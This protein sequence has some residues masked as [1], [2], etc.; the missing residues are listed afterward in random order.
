M[1]RGG[2][3]GHQTPSRAVSQGQDSCPDT[4]TQLQKLE[5]EA[6]LHGGRS[7]GSQGRIDP[8]TYSNPSLGAVEGTSEV[9]LQGS[10][11]VHAVRVQGQQLQVVAPELIS[12]ADYLAHSAATRSV[13]A[14]QRQLLSPA[15]SSLDER[16]DP[17]QLNERPA[18]NAYSLAFPGAAGFYSPSGS[19]VIESI[20]SQPLSS[21]SQQPVRA[22]HH[23]AQG[24][25]S[26]IFP[27]G[28][29]PKAHP[30]KQ[31]QRSPHNP[32]GGLSSGGP[33]SVQGTS[34][35]TPSLPFSPSRTNPLQSSPVKPI[36]S[37]MSVATNQPPTEVVELRRKTLE[38]KRKTLKDV[39]NSYVDK[40]TELF[41]LQQS[42]NMMDYVIW[43]KKQPD[44][45]LAS[46]LKSRQLE[47]RI[48]DQIS[49]VKVSTSSSSNA[50]LSSPAT[51]SA[52][53][54]QEVAAA[55]LKKRLDG[56]DSSRKG[57]PGLG[58][59]S[60]VSASEARKRSSS[61]AGLDEAGEER[62]VKLSI[63]GSEVLTK[64]ETSSTAPSRTLP[65][66]TVIP[67]T[68]TIG[69]KSGGEE[70][71]LVTKVAVD[72]SDVKGLVGL[73]S[74]PQRN[75]SGISGPSALGQLSGNKSL[76]RSPLPPGLSRDRQGTRQGALSAVYDYTIGSQEMIVERAKQEAQVMQ[77]IAELRRDGLWSAKRL[78]RVQEPP[79]HK[80]HW[81]Y[82]LEE[83]QWLAA[84]F[85][86][87]RRWK[88]NAARK[89]ARA[90]A[91]HHQ[92][93]EAREMK[94][95]KEEVQ[96]LKR[97]AGNI[98][99]EIKA[100]WA[101]IEKVVQ[102]KQQ[103]RLDER[104]KKALD[105]QLDFIVGQTEKYSSW[106]TEGLN[107]STAAS[108]AQAS[109]VSS[110]R[111]DRMVDDIEFE[112]QGDDSDDE[113]TIDVEEKQA[114]KAGEVA[115]G[116]SEIELLQRESELPIE[117]LL[118]SLQ[119]AQKKEEEEKKKSSGGKAEGETTKKREEDQPD[120]A[121]LVE[122]TAPDSKIS[123]SKD[124]KDFELSADEEEIVDDDEKTLDEQEE[125]EGTV[126][127]KAEL[128]D[129]AAD[130]E[131]PMEELL[132]RY[133]GAYAEDFDFSDA[134]EDESEEDDDDEEDSSQDSSSEEEE[135]EE[136]EEEEEEDD[137]D[138][139]E[140]KDVGMEY[141]INP[142]KENEDLAAKAS[143]G[144]SE[145]AG[146]NMEIT[147]IAAA[148]QSLQP[149]GYTLSDTQV[150][151]KVPFL[152]RHTLR[153]YQHIG[154]DWLVTMLE[155]KL[156]GIL[157][158]EMG[159]GKTIQT[160]ALLAHL[161]CDE[162]CWGP[163]LIVVPTSV[164]LNWEME[165]KKWCPAFKILTY[166]GSQKERKLKRTG[167]TKSNAFHVCITSY[168]LV[169]QDHQSFRR[170][171]W[172]YLVLDEAQNIK[173]FKSQRWQ[174]LLNFSSQRRLLLTGTPLQNNLMELWSLMHFLMP[175]VFQSHREFKEWFSNPL[176]GMIEGTQEYNEGIIRRLHKVLRP[177][178]L[179]R[180][181]SQVEKQL[182]QK[183]E[184]VIRCRLSKR[185]RFLYDDFMAQRKTKETLSTGHFMSVIN[186]LMQL[187]KV[188]N[189]PDLFEERAIVSPFIM[190]GLLYYTASLVHRVMEYNPL[191]QVSLRA[192]N[193]CIADL[194]ISLP[195]YAAHRTC[196]LQ[197]PRKLI[198]EIDSAPAPPS[199]PPRVKVKPGKLYPSPMALQAQKEARPSPSLVNRP[200]DRASP[201]ALHIHGRGS[202]S[203]VRVAS[204]NIKGTP[205]P[206]GLTQVLVRSASGVSLQPRA[207]TPPQGTAVG[208]SQILQ[209]Q[210]RPGTPPVTLT[211]IS[212]PRSPGTLTLVSQNPQPVPSGTP[213]Q[214]LPGYTGT[215]SGSVGSQL[216]QRRVL[217]QQQQVSGVGTNGR[218][219]LITTQP[220]TV[221][222]QSGSSSSTQQTGQRLL[223]GQIRQLPQGG[224][225][226]IIQTS[227][228]Q[229]I[230]RP[231][232]HLTTQ[233][234]LVNAQRTANS[235]TQV[236]QRSGTPQMVLSHTAAQLQAA[237]Q[238]HQ[239]IQR[240]LTAQGVSPSQAQAVASQLSKVTAAQSPL[241]LQQ[242]QIVLQQQQQPQQVV[243]NA[244]GAS[245]HT[246][247]ATQT[248]TCASS[249][250]RPSS[251][252]VTIV[253]AART[254]NASSPTPGTIKTSSP[255]TKT[256]V[257]VSLA[258]DRTTN[259][260][261]PTP[262]PKVVRASSPCVKTSI[263]TV[264]PKE[265][266]S[267]SLS[268]LSSP[269]LSDSVPFSPLTPLKTPVIRLKPIKLQPSEVSTVKEES[270]ES[271]ELKEAA[272][273]FKKAEKKRKSS[274]LYLESLDKA[275]A[276]DRKACL[277][278]IATFNQQR[279]SAKPVYG[280]DL[281]TAVSLYHTSKPA[282]KRR[283]FSNGVGNVHCYH[284][285][286]GDALRR[287]E[288][289]YKKTR[290]LRSILHT[291]EDYLEELQQINKRYTFVVP[292]VTAPL[293][294]MH[295]SHTPPSVLNSERTL[296]N[297]L[298]S[299]L[300]PKS[301]CLHPIENLMR[302][303]MPELRLIQYDCGKLQTMDGLLRK[304]KTEGSRVLIFTQMTKMLDILERFLNFHGHIYLRLDGTTKVEQRQIMMERFNKDPRIFC[305]IL[306]T[307]SGG[308]GVNL[309]GANAVIFYDSDWNPTM[310][311][312]AQD[313]CHRIG[314]TR[315]VHIYRLISEMSIEEN[316]LKKSNQKRLLID[317][318]I[319][320][321]NFTTAF[322]K[323]HTI[324]DIFDVSKSAGILEDLIEVDK[325]A[326]PQE[327]EQPK[328][329]EQEAKADKPLSQTELEKAL[330]R[331]EDDTDVKAA[332]RA[333]AE[334]DAELAEFD[335]DIPYEGEE[336]KG[337]DESSKLEKELTQLNNQLTPIERYAVV[338]LEDTLE[339]IT[340]E[341]LKEA[342][343]QVEAAK[344]EWELGRLQ[345]LKEL[346]EREAELEEDDVLYTYSREDSE[347]Q[348]Y[349]SQK[350]EIMPIWAP[351]TPPQDDNDVYIDHVM[352]LGYEP[353]IM[354]ESQLPSVFHK[355]ETKKIKVEQGAVVPARKIKSHGHHHHHHH[356]QKSETV[357][358]TPML[359]APPQSLFNRPSAA[360]I[361]MRRE[362]KQQKMRALAGKPV[363]KPMPVVHRPATI[364]TTSLDKLEW[365]I[366]EDWALLQAVQT[367][368][369][370]PLTLQPL[371][372]GHIINWDLVSDIVNACSRTF[373]SPKQCCNRYESVIIPREEGK[374]LYDTNP[375][376]QKK[377]KGIYRV[378]TKNNRPM[379]SSQLHA[380]DGNSSHTMLYSSKF[381]G[382]K[383][384]INKRQP[385][386]KQVLN[387]PLLKNPKHSAIL[388]ESGINYDKPMVPSEVALKRAER[389]AREKKLA[390][391][392]AQQ[393]LAREKK[394]QQEQQQQQRLLAATKQ[395]QA[396]QQG[397]ATQVTAQPVG[398][399]A[400]ATVLQSGTISRTALGTTVTQP[401]R[402]SGTL[403]A[404]V[405]RSQGIRTSVPQLTLPN[406]TSQVRTLGTS[407]P[408][409]VVSSVSSIVTTGQQTRV[410]PTVSL[411]GG[412]QLSMK[413]L[414]QFSQL[415]LM[416]I[417][418]QQLQQLQQQVQQAQSS[419]SGQATSGTVTQ[420]TQ[421]Q[422]ATNQLKA[423][424]RKLQQA[425][426]QA[427]AVQAQAQ[428]QA[429]A[430]SGQLTT[431]QKATGITTQAITGVTHVQLT[432][433]QRQQLAQRKGPTLNTS[434]AE[435]AALLKH[436]QAQQL[437]AQKIK[438]ISTIPVTSVTQLK[439]ITVSGVTVTGVTTLG[440]AGAKGQ[441]VSVAGGM[442]ALA[443]PTA[444]GSGT[445]TT[446]L[447][448]VNLQ[449]I[450]QMKQQKL[451]LAQV[452]GQPQVV[453]SGQQVR[454]S[455]GQATV[456]RGGTQT[457]QQTLVQQVASLQQVGTIGG[458]QVRVQQ[459][460]APRGQQ[461]T[462][463]VQ[464]QRIPTSQLQGQPM[465][466][467]RQQLQQQV[468]RV[469]QTLSIQ[470]QGKPVT[471]IPPGR[472]VPQ[473]L[474]IQQ[475][476]KPVTI[477]P[478]GAVLSSAGK[479]TVSQASV[480]QAQ[481]QPQQ[482]VTQLVTS[483]VTPRTQVQQ[484][485]TPNRT[486][487]LARLVQAQ[488][489]AQ[490]QAQ[491]KAQA[492]AQ[493]QA[494]SQS[495]PAHTVVSQTV[496]VQE[497]SSS[498]GQ[499][500]GAA[501]Q[502][503]PAT[504]QVRVVTT[505]ATT[506]TPVSI[507]IAQ[508]TSKPSP[509][510]Q[511]Q[512]QQRQQ[513]QQTPATTTLQAQ[514][515]QQQQQQQQAS[516]DPQTPQSRVEVLQQG[517]ASSASRQSPY[518]MRLRK[519]SQ[520][521]KD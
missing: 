405:V 519:P 306:S 329:P 256:V 209:A 384:A 353:S 9:P 15:R 482:L 241:Q 495:S 190:V 227:G 496:V 363:V 145:E 442:K 465:P 223:A 419:S 371:V 289:A 28:S 236:V 152:L 229:Q 62:S 327:P 316:I 210:G 239:S 158:D 428:A 173:N 94:A 195:A 478:P 333:H 480:T 105:L 117:E 315:D 129:L 157:A 4:S 249:S 433:A 472:Q 416:K 58:G 503:T 202:P 244:K 156:N 116:V 194:E 430:T 492:Q 21:P 11:S 67:A 245:V 45:Q 77:R 399:A 178:L 375:K 458:Q 166:Y 186:V 29:I 141:L 123:E 85:A 2:R 438:G 501:Q 320:G 88:K 219:Q 221:Q 447:S 502:T 238:L 168:K 41:F 379:K 251:P 349:I 295:T 276:D 338:Y 287:V 373:R 180:L 278:R 224:I 490:A 352:C 199:R 78:P 360:L 489:L 319:E 128:D 226:Q 220:I 149:T 225:V 5:N 434:Q 56:E 63:G 449:Q 494:Q 248:V 136:T 140:L 87:E 215:V 305:F 324:K 507:S 269:S 20:V 65:S 364:E 82:L 299:E 10:P 92:D 450:L 443:I 183:Y 162:G 294:T 187:R 175:H 332:S 53:L 32:F 54:P 204:P 27:D 382:I 425:Q 322:F 343:E 510:Q 230:I 19:P 268:S 258:S 344:R 50:S 469:P 214:Q 293:I 233:A 310:D 197:T 303:D 282:G 26:R 376:K 321:G 398:T 406:V 133:Q 411:Q 485:S 514:P 18:G 35:A 228:G 464:V 418:Q 281:F 198:E 80:A 517:A 408:Q 499:T 154:L 200:S 518:A 460:T 311:A 265:P 512:Q 328:E 260:A 365:L 159:L 390:A 52:Q 138:K 486:P 504:Q 34:T 30:D 253:Q 143:Q 135:L 231:A 377:S 474:S 277:S 86:Q 424:L 46:Y 120:A 440:Q 461:Q 394:Q 75:I 403:A 234:N 113:E 288:V 341:Q 431:I 71:P 334:Q 98:A 395:Q 232:V 307:R 317:V 31:G 402:V 191:K 312:Q 124:D 409:I 391:L 119:E 23:L 339:P 336:G 296:I 508:P 212:N 456:Q 446:Q 125:T 475:Q 59:S 396:Q 301:W 93:Q 444:G 91:K 109:S 262:S 144:T 79:R 385:F 147:D 111:S 99:K 33:S 206:P 131:I 39:Q 213:L 487:Q 72:A 3:L 432:Q 139:D 497:E 457:A 205:G 189:H 61:Q 441:V 196:Q 506:T 415:A 325:A 48:Q 237:Q 40:L 161:A 114:A 351:P 414:G 261:S 284:A 274:P 340:A 297:T 463:T 498:A 132:K 356:H 362:A 51:I 318:S 217:L 43:K 171:K 170:K 83:M 74:P 112:P 22:V 359:P 146:P 342:E 49:E 348:V 7:A 427:Q 60:I 174:T 13:G 250:S 451:I 263:A 12:V 179:R 372:P 468:K 122:V 57:Q 410:T 292:V 240:Q 208:T 95:G 370:L 513:Q 70:A 68:P 454:V 283:P 246:T 160:I 55:Q 100:F 148:A 104:R 203:M 201:S 323:K 420:T 137:Q 66:I 470:Q 421:Q 24:L 337:N 331:A 445:T 182:P 326:E 84:D 516:E 471:I 115:G 184:H 515:Q 275:R 350:E 286:I 177:F 383:M 491:A 176:G 387:N 368:L 8:V 97:I 290:N 44:L 108:S 361:R 37:I 366:N 218:A 235:T 163:H 407:S 313:R 511:Q 448:K 521:S 242:R 69:N 172:K 291:P 165:L 64:S 466:T 121:S 345:G 520:S 413:N 257:A 369:E 153:E 285:L 509:Q 17:G 14:S 169:I 279:C 134:D 25:S 216:G 389:I 142:E 102:Y 16:R 96:K 127:H 164:M 422:A 126:D 101:N 76:I 452:Q 167:W 476:G 426:A 397:T 346:E 130:G 110:P 374:I 38:E 500:K 355:K 380:Q 247:P 479:V 335:E 81:D 439:G 207:S 118:S 435:I 400:G 367:L 357:Q 300:K 459:V 181:K 243:I 106:L 437:Q 493:A 388:A 193:L 47:E 192:L 90:V 404:Q 36:K 378:S 264:S 488:Q 107:T 417:K 473:T 1:Q 462:G 309:T 73:A 330:A 298:S 259:A 6:V 185:Q 266:T 308:M 42:H 272:E 347:N 252:S 477:I 304:L 358:Q 484:Q 483:V 467:V 302:L 429:Q 401:I 481:K 211:A 381:D 314:Q 103:S 354:T 155:K 393:K 412:T 267:P 273:K 222:L 255:S 505:P 423:E 270:K 386:L 453:T 89:L 151:T 188:C 392:Q 150:K 455:S 271:K 254:V 280:Q 436:H